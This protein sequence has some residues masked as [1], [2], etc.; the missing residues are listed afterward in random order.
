M[1]F[2]V[3][4]LKLVQ[5]S[6]PTESRVIIVYRTAP[7]SVTLNDPK[8]QISSWW[9]YSALS[10]LGTLRGT[11]IVTVKYLYGLTP[12]SRTDLE[13]L[14]EIFNDTKHRAVSLRQRSFLCFKGVAVFSPSKTTCVLMEG[15]QR[16]ASLLHIIVLS[17]TI[18][19]TCLYLYCFSC[20]RCHG[21]SSTVSE[22][23]RHSAI[24]LSGVKLLTFCW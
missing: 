23:T 21:N 22:S 9:H 4:N 16:T 2:N 20:S 5:D 17:V 11:D 7:F 24:V 14:S 8:T 15:V 10:I 13:W 19:R 12:Y 6:R 18:Y 3:N 1:I